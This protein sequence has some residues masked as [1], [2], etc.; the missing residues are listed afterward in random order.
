MSN[1]HNKPPEFGDGRDF[2]LM[3]L[4]P[5]ILRLILQH[6]V[7]GSACVVCN[8]TE[9]GLILIK[10]HAWVFELL[11]ISKSFSACAR[12]AIAGSL[13]LFH[14][15]HNAPDEIGQII[16]D[17]VDHTLR[18]ID[19]SHGIPESLLSQ[20]RQ[21]QIFHTSIASA[22]PL[23]RFDVSGFP[24]LARVGVSVGPVEDIIF[25][26][27]VRLFNSP[28]MFEQGNG[29]AFEW[30]AGL[31]DMSTLPATEADALLAELVHGLSSTEHPDDA[32][33]LLI[34][35]FAAKLREDMSTIGGMLS[36][37]C[38]STLGCNRSKFTGLPNTAALRIEFT[39]EVAGDP[40]LVSEA[41]SLSDST[42]VY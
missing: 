14:V 10:Q 8:S 13:V 11:T 3:G 38:D 9:D 23:A 24:N 32:D 15:K 37:I 25:N 7:A 34:P 27:S 26:M 19:L 36:D 28:T 35:M 1:D 16:L 2:T 41:Q 12:E 21:L 29:R 22:I 33:H 4:P 39:T 6:A 20:C 17:E 40:E 42:S 18:P 30:A 5:E 31:L